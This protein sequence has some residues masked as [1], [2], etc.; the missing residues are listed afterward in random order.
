MPRKSK[1]KSSAAIEAL[2]SLSV[3]R[4]WHSVSLAEIAERSGLSMIALH[5]QYGGKVGILAA[6]LRGIDE[7]TLQGAVTSAEEKVRDRLFDLVMRRF[8]ALQPHRESLRVIF[9]DL[10]TDPLLWPCCGLRLAKTASLMLEASG[11]SASGLCGRLKAKGMAAVYLATLRTWLND[12]SPDMAKTMAALD[13][14]LVRAEWAAERMWGQ[15]R[16]ARE[17]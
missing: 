7:A 9:Y 10:V 4:G 8:D 17:G 1:E 2:F 15:R 16:G 14:G 11:V 6:F 12:D 5:Q 3:E 13:R